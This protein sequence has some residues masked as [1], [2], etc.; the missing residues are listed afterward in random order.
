M[1]RR[2]F[3]LI[4]SIAGHG[5]WYY[6]KDTSA[7]FRAWQSDGGTMYEQRADGSLMRMA[8]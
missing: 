6:F 3:V 7:L 2:V 5:Y 8:A 4:R 1:T